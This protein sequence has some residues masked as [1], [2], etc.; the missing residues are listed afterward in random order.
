METV[1]IP[2]S[3]LKEIAEGNRKSAKDYAERGL[4]EMAEWSEGRASV[5]ENLIAVYAYAEAT[6]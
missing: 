6:V 3:I 5:A 1:T 2:L 4:L